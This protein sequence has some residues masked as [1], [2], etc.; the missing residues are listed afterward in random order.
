[1]P[2][3][4]KDYVDFPVGSYWVYEDSISGNIDSIYLID[5]K[6]YIFDPQHTCYCYYEILEQN[7]YS[8]YNNHLRAQLVRHGRS[9]ILRI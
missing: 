6:T 7:F 2:Q 8:S 5:Y 1:M 3:E 4:F 9:I